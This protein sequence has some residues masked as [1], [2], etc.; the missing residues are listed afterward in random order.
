MS[1]VY[2]ACS[3][4]GNAF[5]SAETP[6]D[7]SVRKRRW[8]GEWALE[9]GE[10]AWEL[11]E[12]SVCRSAAVDI[13]SPGRPSPLLGKRLTTCAGADGHADRAPIHVWWRKG[14][15]E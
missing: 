7:S 3:N 14:M 10:W 13:F 5:E 8:M 11:G 4:E 6:L 12:W 9:S 1:I 2:I 15:E